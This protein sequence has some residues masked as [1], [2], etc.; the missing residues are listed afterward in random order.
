MNETPIRHVRVQEALWRR[1]QNK[2][3]ESG[4]TTSQAVR[5]ALLN[6]VRDAR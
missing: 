4:V 5:T 3:Q 1:V 6:Y 2:A